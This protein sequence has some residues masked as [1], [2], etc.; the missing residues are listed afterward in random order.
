MALSERLG[1]YV[2]ACFPGLWIQ[3]FEHDDAIAEIATLCRA[4]DWIL[5]TWDLDRGLAVAGQAD[6]SATV[7]TAADP[8]AALA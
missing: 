3:S 1:E 8:L 4:Q 6:G 5:A 7:P 2:R